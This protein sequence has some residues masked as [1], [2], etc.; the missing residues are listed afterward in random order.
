MKKITPENFLEQIRLTKHRYRVQ[1]Y[2]AKQD[3][4]RLAVQH[5]KSSFE[6]RGFAGER[7]KWKKREHIYKHPILEKTGELKNSIK[8]IAPTATNRITVFTETPYAKYHNDPTGTWHRNQYT[9][10]PT[11]QRQ[12]MGNSKVLETKLKRRVEECIKNT[13]ILNE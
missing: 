4:G 6:R 7:R 11:Q 13:L 3:M 8:F 10:K 12:F 1:L 9:S 2:L 5:F